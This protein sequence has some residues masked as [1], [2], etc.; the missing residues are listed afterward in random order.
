MRPELCLLAVALS[1]AVACAAS[2][3]HPGTAELGAVRASDPS[4]RADDLERGRGLY[5][6]K[7]SGCH[8]AI[9]PARFGADAWPGKI[10]RMRSERRVHLADDEVRDIERYLVGVSAVARD[11]A[12]L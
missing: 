10:E 3:P 4:V 9:E 8:T 5:L 6:A 11:H 12:A 1:G 7:C 2:L